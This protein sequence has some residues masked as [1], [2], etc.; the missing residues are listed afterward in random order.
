VSSPRVSLSPA[1]N[2]VSGFRKQY[3]PWNIGKRLRENHNFSAV[4]ELLL[5]TSMNRERGMQE[6]RRNGT[7]NK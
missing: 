2:I 4:R 6:E 5:G 7:Q 3:S 1:L